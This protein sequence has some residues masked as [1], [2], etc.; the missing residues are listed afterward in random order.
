[1]F[2]S[3]EVYRGS[4]ELGIRKWGQK[5]ESLTTQFDDWDQLTKAQYGQKS[6]D[7]I[8]SF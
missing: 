6:N 7:R 1:M 2:L 8:C 5:V 3:L 4:E